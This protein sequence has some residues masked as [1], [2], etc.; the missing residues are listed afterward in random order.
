MRSRLA[1]AFMPLWFLLGVL[2][3]SAL[4]SYGILLV[5]GDVWALQK[6]IG[7]IALA[8]LLLSIFP[9]RKMLALSWGDLGF[10]PVQ[11]MLRQIARGFGLALLTLM[12]AMLILYALDIQQWDDGRGWTIGKLLEKTLLALLIGLLVGLGE[13]SLFRG[14]L[15]S[16]LNAR[17]GAVMAALLS[18]VYFAYL[19]FLNAKTE[20]PYAEL[21]FASPWRLLAEGFSHWLQPDIYPAWLALLMVGLF[22]AALR[23]RYTQSLGLC[24]GCH[25]GWVWLI[26]MMKELCNPNPDS[27]LLGWVSSYDAIIGPFISIWLAVGL[28]WMIKLD[29]KQT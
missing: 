11:V 8:L 4:L 13:E 16:S 12:P 5:F 22:L 10:A 20:I 29:P 21:D 25:A 2:T 6:L 18:A 28:L 1:M 27:P 7:R 26:R 23:W 14:L 3:M 9:L 24:I 17:V 15:W 19:H